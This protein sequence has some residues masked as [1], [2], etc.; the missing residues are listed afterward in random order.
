MF[1]VL[2]PTWNNLPYLKLCIDAL[3]KH[4]HFR[5]EIIVHVNEGNDGTAEWLQREGIRH[6]VS[7]RNEG[8]CVALNVAARQ[9][10]TDF[11][12]Y[13]NDDMF[14]LPGWD[15]ALVRRVQQLPTDCFMLSSTCIE[16]RAS[17]NAC[18]VVADYGQDE[19][20]FNRAALLNN[21][22]RHQ[23]ADWSGS[24]WPPHLIHR[25][26]WEVIGGMDE[27]YSPGM[28]SDDDLAMRMWLAGCR[29]FVGVGNSMVY[30]FMCRSTGRVVKNNGRRQFLKRHRIK[31][32]TFRRYYLREGLQ[33]MIP[34]PEPSGMMFRTKKFVDRLAAGL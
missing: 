14:V 28:A 18:V 3:H 24:K 12:L 34:L 31:A 17:G 6:S 9:A 23:R 33:A 10:T 22:H 29:I 8:I 11:L 13:L 7:E 5:H 2:I 27:A 20:Q 1:S 25:R 15:T 4:S 32:S 30:H 21:F 26:W 19:R 16:P